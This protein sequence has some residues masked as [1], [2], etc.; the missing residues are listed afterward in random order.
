MNLITL[1]SLV[2]ATSQV[3]QSIHI[4]QQLGEHSD[5]VESGL[6]CDDGWL[7]SSK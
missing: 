6:K 1:K 7:V 3:F 5:F 2:D 4:F